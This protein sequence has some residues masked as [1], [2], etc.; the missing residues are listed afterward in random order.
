MNEANKKTNSSHKLDSV[1]RELFSSKKEPR[2]ETP[3]PLHDFHKEVPTSW[4]AS[5]NTMTKKKPKK[6]LLHS[7]KFRQVLF[8]A[9]LFLVGSIIFSALTF[10]QGG[11]TVSNK[12]I[13]IVVL[14]NSFVDGGEELP[15][16]VRVANRNRTD[17][18]IADLRIEYSRG[19]GGANDVIRNRISLGEVGSG[20]I[21][22]EIIPIIVFGQQGTIRDIVFT[23][24]YRVANSN[25]IFIKEYVY[26]INIANSP[27]DVLVN[28]PSNV[29]SNQ[30]FETEIIL[31]QN[32]T[33][34]ASD[35]MV[36]AI[37][38][39][40]FKFASAT[41]R[42][43]FGNDT[44]LL[45]DL[46]PGAERT[47]R[48]EGSIRAQ[49]GEE[50]IITIV[51]G[52]Q[53]PQDEQE[54]GVQFTATPLGITIGTSFLAANVRFGEEE[55]T[56][57]VAASGQAQTFSIE[58][59]NRLQ[60]SLN[61]VEVVLNLGGN[62]FDP[63]R[64]SVNQGFFNTNTNQIIW[65][66]ANNTS[67]RNASSGATG[68]LSFTL[69][70]RAGV[71]NPIVTLNIDARGVVSGSGSSVEEVKNIYSGRIQIES[72]VQLSASVLHSDGPFSNTGPTPPT[73][74]QETSYTVLW[75]VS[76]SVNNMNE[77][78]ITAQLPSYVVW[79]NQ[80]FPGSEDVTY[81][82][83]TREVRWNAGSVSS[84]VSATRTAQFMVGFN[85]SLNHIDTNPILVGTSRLE[86]VDAFT[87]RD[88]TRTINSLTTSLFRDSAYDAANDRVVQ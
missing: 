38:P 44:W 8:V 86:A 12:N 54:I 3:E 39:S 83:V 72:D 56:D 23:L 42:P 77:T 7:R 46:A 45:G 30:S 80:V 52:T 81:N 61:D 76:S 69:T 19:A 74:G 4:K 33:E 57:F 78:K 11:T 71:S 49:S 6:H 67:L 53:S 70:P 37:Y 34:V 84:G 47:I 32:S 15:L 82:P 65:S 51:S 9:L 79:K 21:V 85:P 48:I 25:A 66:G 58:W 68:I 20:K 27:V 5:E 35:M 13:D 40:G 75:T 28:G 1:E 41:P 24:E 60:N 55:G 88:I 62:G 50:R 36:S 43:D 14:G 18:E 63:S 16:Q 31:V 29:V 17:L 2:I 64:V 59:E 73:V 87:G 10:F 22:E 26:P